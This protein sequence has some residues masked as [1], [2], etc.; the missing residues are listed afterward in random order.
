MSGTPFR[1]DGEP[2]PFVRYSNGESQS[3]HNYGY[4]SAL[5]DS[6]CRPVFFP[7]YEGQ[8]E[9]QSSDGRV[10]SA[11][12]QDDVTFRQADERLN[13]AIDVGGNWIKEVLIQASSELDNIRQRGHADAGGL[14]LAK[15]QRSARQI[16][17]VLKQITNEVPA[18]A[19]SD[20]TDSSSIIKGFATGTEKWIVAVKMVSEGVDIPRLRVLV[21]A[22]NVTTEMFF[23]QAVG[24]VVRVL[25]D[26]DEQ[27]AYFYIPHDQ[28][29]ISFAQAIKEE[30]THVLEEEEDYA[31]IEDTG[32]IVPIPREPNSTGFFNPISAE[33][34][35]NGAVIDS[36]IFDQNEI[37]RARTIAASAGFPISAEM[38]AYIINIINQQRGSQPTIPTVAPESEAAYLKR[39]RLRRDITKYVNILARI[40]NVEHKVI[41]NQWMRLGNTAQRL[42][43]IEDLARKRDWLK[44]EVER[45][46]Q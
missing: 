2:I 41:H 7:K 1:S 3:D 14:V 43:S 45:Y 46:N 20:E 38:V 10:I 21:Y 12:F 28:R 16:R 29:L 33:A 13:T 27:A 42:A 9:W 40:Q 34:Q 24:R 18:I 32:E 22:T 11:T 26:V 37:D 6:V 25:R 15:D 23:R 30:R 17:E 8:M 39:E 31:I 44:R 35:A 5:R 36:R 19:T 4:E